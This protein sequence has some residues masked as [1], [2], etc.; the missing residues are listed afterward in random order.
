VRLEVFNESGA[1]IRLLLQN[2]L[3]PGNYLSRWDGR[4]EAGVRVAAGTYF[5][6][7]S[8]GDATIVTTMIVK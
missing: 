1:Q 8:S 6:R 5:C 7:L 4:N 3:P 2:H